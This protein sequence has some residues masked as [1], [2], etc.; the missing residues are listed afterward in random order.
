MK[1]KLINDIINLHSVYTGGKR[2]GDAPFARLCRMSEEE[3][4]EEVL[5]LEEKILLK[6]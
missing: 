1:T 6:L 4:R 2:I 3:L 5:V